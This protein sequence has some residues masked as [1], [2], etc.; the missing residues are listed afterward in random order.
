MG[1]KGR[2]GK[3]PTKPTHPLQ[4]DP[5]LG[6]TAKGREGLG[7]CALRV[8]VCKAVRDA[9]GGLRQGA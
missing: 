7:K 5:T 8:D 9:R 4:E 2:A 1:D 3:K 6:V